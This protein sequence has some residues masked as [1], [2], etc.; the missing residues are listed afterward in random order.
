M[1]YIFYLDNDRH[2]CEELRKSFSD[3]EKYRFFSSSSAADILRESNT[4]S[5]RTHCK[6]AIIQINEPGEQSSEMENFTRGL[7][8]SG[9]F[10]GLILVHPSER[11]EEIKKSIELSIDAYIQR[12]G[13]T[14]PRVHNAV[15]R[16][17]SDHMLQ[18]AGK[19]LNIAL[20]T[21]AAFLI[22]SGIIVVLKYL[23]SP[24]S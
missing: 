13:S 8:R 18:K 23:F 4:V 10:T 7:E 11:S 9:K 21:V 3:P 1:T 22:L 24:D 15:H 14:I 2:F 6:V 17:I 19:S 16:L 20:C 5:R 12:N